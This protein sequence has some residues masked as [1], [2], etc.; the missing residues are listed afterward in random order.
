MTAKWQFQ[1]NCISIIYLSE[2][3]C[4]CKSRHSFSLSLFLSLSHTL[5]L[6]LFLFLTL[7]LSVGVLS[8]ILSFVLAKKFQQHVKEKQEVTERQ[9]RVSQQDITQ[10][11]LKNCFM[12]LHALAYKN[13]LV[14]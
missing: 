13:E 5:S 11:V 1:A 6:S 9:R 2:H 14:S 3:I 4:Y 10:Q 7:S 12:L 8:D